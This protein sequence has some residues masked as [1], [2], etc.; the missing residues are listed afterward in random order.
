MPMWIDAAAAFQK[1]LAA[2]PLT[3]YQAGELVL[4]EGSRTDRLLILKRGNVAVFKEGF[5]IVSVS[6]PGAVFGEISHIASTQR[7][8]ARLGIDVD[9]ISEKRYIKVVVVS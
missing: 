8:C 7:M 4:A 2:L 9:V 6:Q 5:E 3:S 1:S